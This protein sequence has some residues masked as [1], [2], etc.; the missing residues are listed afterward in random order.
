MKWM[1]AWKAN[2]ENAIL[3]F[4]CALLGLAEWDTPLF[5]LTVCY[6]FQQ[7]CWVPFKIFLLF[8]LI[9]KNIL[10]LSFMCAYIEQV[11][12]SAFTTLIL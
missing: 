9:F 1:M 12:I 7:I 10:Q 6:V 8:E 5:M 4:S 3:H 11:D 2:V